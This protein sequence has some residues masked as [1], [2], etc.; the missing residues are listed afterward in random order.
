MIIKLEEGLPVNEGCV[1]HKYVVILFYCHYFFF[2]EKSVISSIIPR[3][4]FLSIRFARVPQH[5]NVIKLIKQ[6]RGNTFIYNYY[7]FFL[8]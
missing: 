6:I 3:Q 7:F 8:Y 5:E 2:K 4:Q 1:M